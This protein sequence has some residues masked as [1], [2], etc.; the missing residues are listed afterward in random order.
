M[1]TIKNGLII[2]NLWILR[3]LLYIPQV[4]KYIIII[5]F[6]SSISYYL[7]FHY[8]NHL[9]SR[10]DKKLH[11]P[12]INLYFGDARVIAAHVSHFLQKNDS[13][14]LSRKEHTWYNI[15]CIMT[16]NNRKTQHLEQESIVVLW[17]NDNTMGMLY[18]NCWFIFETFLGHTNMFFLYWCHVEI[19]I[20][21]NW[22]TLDPLKLKISWLIIIYIF[23]DW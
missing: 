13:K 19:Y 14:K 10:I 18:S 17:R 21:Q 8:L 9:Y 11:C 16:N 22:W 23:F 20:Y 15:R 7:L 1:C 2:Q 5:C 3:M 12:S 4:N 6:A